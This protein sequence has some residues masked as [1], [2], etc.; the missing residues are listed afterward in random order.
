MVEAVI[1][2]LI[3]I[4]VI[5]LCY[6]LIIWALAEVGLAIPAMVAHII[7]VILVLICILILWRLLSPHIGNPLL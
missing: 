2:A 5:V 1:R 6:F 7:L 3:T 4:A